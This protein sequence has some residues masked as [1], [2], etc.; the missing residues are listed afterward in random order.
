[1][2]GRSTRNG[3]G[4]GTIL[5]TGSGIDA[6]RLEVLR[7]RGYDIRQ[8]PPLL[9]EEQ[10]AREL[11]DVVAYLHGGEER[12]TR[13]ALE[14]AKSTLKVVAFLGVGYETF[15]DMAAADELKMVVTFTPG[16]AR[17]SV[18]T[19]TVAQIIN[20]NLQMFRLIGNRYPDWKSVQ[21]L[22]YELSARNV[23]IVGMGVIG[24][25]IAEML[26]RAFD[27]NVA[28]YSRTPKKRLERTLGM[29]FKALPDLAEW[30]DI[31]VVM[32]P[33]NS[34]T[35]SM[36]DDE[37]LGGVRPGTILINTARPSVV[38]P[39]ALYTSMETGRI[40]L[41]AFDGFY[42]K[43]SEAAAKLLEDFGSRMIV[44]GHVASHTLQGMGRMLDQAVMSIDNLLSGKPDPHTVSAAARIP[45][46]PP[47]SR[48]P[49]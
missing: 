32:V 2:A 35:S 33:G 15:V 5:V 39:E 36:I 19:F 41:A 11:K 8:P 17:D 24:S 21:D 18:A 44:T 47:S 45:R 1:M 23:G 4:K 9:T 22:P 48:P 10:L 28:Y 34:T 38:D 6:R 12:A 13:A 20:A 31:L 26:R 43:D 16:A 25:R 3:A 46:R 37:V 29:E 40:R 30:S 7:A 49:G 42:S 27:A 14:S